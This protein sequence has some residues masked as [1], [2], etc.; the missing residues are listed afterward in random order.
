[1][2][3][4]P[5]GPVGGEHGALREIRT[6]EGWGQGCFHRESLVQE[7]RAVFLLSFFILPSLDL[8]QISTLN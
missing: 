3:V 7:T 1:M 6:F 2:M 5:G 8:S 4:K